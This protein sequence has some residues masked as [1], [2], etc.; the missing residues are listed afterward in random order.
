MRAQRID[1]PR[2]SR[3]FDRWMQGFLLMHRGDV[4]EAL[5]VAQ[6]QQALTPESDEDGRSWW[7]VVIGMLLGMSGT[8]REG[9]AR[10]AAARLKHS[11]GE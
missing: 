8:G 3:L 11:Q 1:P 9:R 2:S 6:E 4:D 10:R 7:A 5:A